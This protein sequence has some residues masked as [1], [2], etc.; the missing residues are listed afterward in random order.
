MIFISKSQGNKI[1]GR[2]EDSIGPWWKL[3]GLDGIIYE[4]IVEN[5]EKYWTHRWRKCNEVVRISVAKSFLRRCH[6]VSRYGPTIFAT[7]PTRACFA[8]CRESPA[9]SAMRIGMHWDLASLHRVFSAPTSEERGPKPARGVCNCWEANQSGYE[10]YTY[11]TVIS[12]QRK[13]GTK[14]NVRTFFV[15]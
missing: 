10:R 8:L 15:S 11:A 2:M 4:L 9:M 7:G 6:L 1:D 12:A 3:D 5:K 14:A 13:W